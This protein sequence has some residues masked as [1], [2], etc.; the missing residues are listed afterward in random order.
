MSLEDLFDVDISG[1]DFPRVGHGEVLQR[2]AC[3]G[4]PA[5]TR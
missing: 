1:R 5:M 3:P 4:M 2:G